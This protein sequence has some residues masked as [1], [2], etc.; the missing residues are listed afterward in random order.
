MAV[1]GVGKIGLCFALTLERASYAVLGV[2]ADRERVEQ[3]RNKAVRT[4]E[5]RVQQALA[6]ARSV[7]V[8]H[9]LAAVRSFGPDC[10]FIAVDTPTIETGGYD[11]RHVDRVLRDLFALGRR[12]APTDLVLLCTTFPGYC[13]SK[14]AEASDYGYALSY[15]PWF[16]AQG[17]IMADLERPDQILI[18][19]AD[20]AAGARLEA[21]YRRVC[22]NEPAVHR[23]SRLS[24]EIA[25]L[26][27]NCFLTMKI[28]F[29]NAIGD[30]ATRAGAERDRVLDAVG[31]DG[32]IGR[33]CLRYGFGYGGP[34]FPRDN[35]ALHFF[36]M[37]HDYNLF[38]AQAT[39][40]ANRSHL[41]FQVGQYLRAHREDEVIHVHGVTYK[42]G[43]EM[44]EESQPLALARALAAA[45]RRVVIH[46]SPAVATQLRAEFGELF[47]YEIEGALSVT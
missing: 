7:E 33:G 25:K 30:L 41:A 34:C 26:A 8:V 20:P 9:D 46:E 44:L 5:P 23:M 12:D 40:E 35:R 42:A 16:V 17:S 39:D 15:S 31:G 36:A 28:A 45:G 24:A 1:I 14:V 4:P 19:E 37:Q 27:T 11:T 21:L 38:Q 6:A 22:S 3:I 32:R 29:A 13:D 18:G 2:D 47:E 10:I 43:T